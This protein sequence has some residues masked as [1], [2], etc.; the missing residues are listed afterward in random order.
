MSVCHKMSESQ[1]HDF[2]YRKDKN[3]QVIRSEHKLL[4]ARYTLHSH[5][6]VATSTRNIL[7]LA[8]DGNERSMCI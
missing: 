1:I 7:D 8:L 6:I 3:R 4:N 5:G 2:I